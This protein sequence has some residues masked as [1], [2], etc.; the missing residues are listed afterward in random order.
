[1]IARL[2][3]LGITAF[4]IT[5]N[6]WLWRMEFGAH[7]DEIDVPLALVW[8][9]ILTAP[10]SSSLSVY[11]NEVRMGY[12]EFSTAVGQ[13]MALFDADKPPQEGVFIP[14]GDQVHLAG[15]IAIGDFTNR[16]KFD[17]RVQ[18]N[19]G[20]EWQEL[21]LKITWHRAIVGL[22]SLATN[23][24]VQL[25]I[26]GE[27]GATLERTLAFADLKNP[28]ALIHVFTG[29][30]M[31]GWLGE[32]DWPALA[33][34][35]PAAARWTARRTHLKIGTEFIPIYQ[36]ETR[37]LDRAITIDVS[38]LGEILRVDLPGNITARIDA[39]NHP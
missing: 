24:V 33:N 12:C 2:T 31:D 30:L 6:V 28:A 36:L 8:K 32:M 11:Q 22:H 9:K 3:F 26:T 18:F 23:Q 35:P 15:N 4:W 20:R 13:E 1:M 21:N 10:D 7:Q 38:T 14:A 25:K 17:G 5:M 29:N 27:D 37:V 34:V 39:L 19:P 16:L